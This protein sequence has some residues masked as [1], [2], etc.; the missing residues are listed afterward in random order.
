MTL[1][2]LVVRDLGRVPYTEALALQ[3]EL[4]ALRQADRI[5]DTLLLLEH[6]PVIT[7]G[8]RRDAQTHVLAAGDVPVVQV[9][10]GGDVTWH[11]PGQLVGY[12]ILYLQ[13]HERDVHVL[14]RNLEAAFIGLLATLGL[15][16]CRRP[17]HTGVWV[18]PGPSPSP[19]PK[20]LVSLGVAIQGWVTF[21]G[22]ALNVDCDLTAFARIQPCGLDAQVMGSLA[23]LGATV[24]E[25]RVLRGLV[26]SAVAHRLSRDLVSV[27]HASAR[28]VD[29]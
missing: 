15:D 2:T 4:V 25:P 1:P 11:G 12:P 20:K 27:P 24:P 3:H 26:A 28:A 6:P 8:R 10:R 17:P 5:P 14:L 18:H 19:S 23:T 21:H 16:A 22:F 29:L 9:D 7:L 13:E